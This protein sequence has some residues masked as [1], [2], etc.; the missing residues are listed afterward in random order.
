MKI[1]DIYHKGTRRGKGTNPKILPIVCF[2]PHIGIIFHQLFARQQYF[3]C[4]LIG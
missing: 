4:D 3:S 2:L 1:G